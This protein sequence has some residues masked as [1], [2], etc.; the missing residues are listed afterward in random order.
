M[1]F[2]AF[3]GKRFL[4]FGVANRKSIAYHVAQGLKEEGAAVIYIVQNDGLRESLKKLLKD[5]SVYSCDVEEEGAAQRLAAEI[6]PRQGPF[7]G[8]VHSIA[9]AN[10]REG[11]K[12]FHETKRGD[13]LQATQI[14]A[15]SLV[16]LAGAFKPYLTPNASVVS[17][18]ISS[19]LVTAENYGYMA[20]IKASLL[21][22][23]RYL[24]KSFSHD[25]RVRF[26]IVAA[27]PLKTSS[28]AGI[29]GYMDN[30]LYAEKL[31][32]RKQ[33]LATTEVANTVLFLLSDRSSG[34]NGTEIVVDAGLGM[35][36]FDKEVVRAAVRPDQS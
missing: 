17:M 25:S 3:E 28:S 19:T 34:V 36:Y 12:P 5:E 4:V 18:G 6:G 11:I 26:N 10:F 20:P 7:D 33:A 13:Y 24:A 27:G 32:F 30:Y 23:A 9:F 8:M 21:T 15:F 16:E 35:N 14:S 22:M 31:T 2:L 29:P 1:S